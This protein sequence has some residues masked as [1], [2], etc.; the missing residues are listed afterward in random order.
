[1][2]LGRISLV[3]PPNWVHME[4][5]GIFCVTAVAKKKLVQGRNEISL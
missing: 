2:P 5:K 1:M 3:I 4:F